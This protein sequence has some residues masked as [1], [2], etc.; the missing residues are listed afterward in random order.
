MH[1][2]I[3]RVNKSV[4]NSLGIYISVPFCR[5]KCTYCNFAS[6]VY[7]ASEHEHYIERVIED[8]RGAGDFAA[9][10][11]LKLPRDVD[12]I[13]FGGGTPTLLAAALIKEIFCTIRSEFNVSAEAEITVE[14]APGQLSDETLSAMVAAGVNRV[15]LGVQ[16]FVDQEAALSGR[17]HTRAKIFEEIERLRR[18]GIENLNV[19]L[20]AGLAGQ[21]HASWGRIVGG[22]G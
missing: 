9:A 2:R 7:P 13:Y 6:G 17:L 5:S 8:L 4:K 19:D 15:S 11:G 12:S 1:E 22:A 3:N 10:R 21:T 14:C 18:A 20:I 16:S